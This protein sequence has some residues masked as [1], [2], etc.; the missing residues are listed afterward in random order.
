[1]ESHLDLTTQLAHMV[2]NLCDSSL[3]KFVVMLTSRFWHSAFAYSL[4]KF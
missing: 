2:C 1:M 4:F 3:N